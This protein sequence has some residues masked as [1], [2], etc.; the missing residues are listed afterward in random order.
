MFNNDTIK[1][2][3]TGKQL[4]IFWSRPDGDSSFRRKTAQLADRI[5]VNYSAAVKRQ[6]NMCSKTRHVNQ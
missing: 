1:P 2:E 4:Q 3:D 5:L 6:N